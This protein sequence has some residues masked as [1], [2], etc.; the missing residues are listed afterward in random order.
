MSD[1]APGPF[2][3]LRS[4]F[5]TAEGTSAGTAGAPTNAAGGSGA[6]ASAVADA[7]S[8]IKKRRGR[9]PGPG[10]ASGPDG[11]EIQRQ[12]ELAKLQADLDK[13]FDPS[14]WRPVVTLPA[15]T[16]ALITG[17]EHWKIP[18]EDA[19]N[20]ALAASTAMRYTA[21]Q[22]PAALAWLLFA[23]QAV[24]IYAPRTLLEMQLRKQER[25]K[26]KAEE[27]PANANP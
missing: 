23:V 24:M 15:N 14:M 27:K 11:S 12:A 2:A 5:S 18:R 16:A 17:H 21:P 4:V 13:L 8:E 9:P 26:K 3:R 20:L 10:A 6:V 22:N 7:K 1:A 25:E 19:D